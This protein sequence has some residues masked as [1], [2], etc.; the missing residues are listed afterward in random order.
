MGGLGGIKEGRFGTRTD[1]GPP[2]W[3]VLTG[4]G[5]GRVSCA[6]CLRP[7]TPPLRLDPRPPPWLECLGAAH[8]SLSSHRRG[9]LPTRFLLPPPPGGLPGPSSLLVRS[10]PLLPSLPGPPPP[11][12]PPPFLSRSV[13]P[14]PESIPA[15]EP[16]R[17]GRRLP[18]PL[19][20]WRSALPCVCLRVRPPVRG[21]GEHTPAP[22]WAPCLSRRWGA[23]ARGPPWRRIAGPRGLL[24]P[25]PTPTPGGTAVSERWAGA[26]GFAQVGLLL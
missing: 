10:L 26:Q 14:G 4:R 2:G 6:A 11:P 21:P 20:V 12:P 8:G 22:P 7:P 5:G 18:D 25:P 23:P 19:A 16:E 15:W 24:S 17:P 9:I 1:G 13:S 3:G